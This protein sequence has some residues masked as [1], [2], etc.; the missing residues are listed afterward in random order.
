MKK[1][2]SFLKQLPLGF[3]FVISLSS[4]YKTDSIV[5][6]ICYICLKKSIFFISSVKHIGKEISCKQ[7]EKALEKH[8]RKKQNVSTIKCL[9]V[10]LTGQKNQMF[11]KNIR[12]LVK[13]HTFP[14]HHQ[15]FWTFLAQRRS[16][17]NFTDR[18]L[19]QK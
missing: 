8:S 15:G 5:N 9:V 11:T 7:L 19:T 4:Y 14:S 13:L 12:N 6:E 16:R 18:P 1:L 2:I 17:R 10:F 3:R